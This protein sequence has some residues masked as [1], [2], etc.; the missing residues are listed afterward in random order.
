VDLQP[1]TIM[2][3][4]RTGRAHRELL[5]LAV[6]VLGACDRTPAELAVG[7][8]QCSIPA[9]LILPGGPGKDGIPALTNPQFVGASES[10]AA[11]LLD[12]DRVIGLLFGDRALAVPLNIGW[13]HEIVNLDVDGA[14]VAITHCP[15]TGSSL[16]F[17]RSVIGGAE[18]GV[19]GLLYQNNLIMY[20]RTSSESLWPQMLR[21]AR[22]GTSDGTSLTMLPVIEMSWHGWKELHP[23]TRVVSSATGISRDYRSYPYGSYDR[24]DNADLLFPFSIDRRRPP[25]E[26]VLGIPDG[27][28]GGIGLPFGALNA[29]GPVAVV[30]VTVR[31]ERIVVFW[32]ASR[33]AAMAYRSRLGAVELQFEVRDGAIVDRATGSIWTVDG[34]AIEGEFAGE[35]LPAVA[36]AYIA[37][38]FAWAKFHSGA[39]L[40]EVE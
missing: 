24:T 30:D 8:E 33:A 40:W 38:W 2:A 10:G 23:D 25:K 4:A 36:E 34:R 20:D 35:R 39:T 37:Y 11:Y 31:A 14:K 32:D 5:G 27:T 22:C 3:G 16:A 26:R 18:F 12:D 17:D 9:S 13:H 28:T 19:S 7:N 1:D 15:L 29:L 6:L 21:G